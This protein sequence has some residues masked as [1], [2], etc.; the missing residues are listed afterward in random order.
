LK[1]ERKTETQ[2]NTI[3]DRKK[4]RLTRLA[5]HSPTCAGEHLCIRLKEEGRQR[6]KKFVA[7]KEITDST[8]E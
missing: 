4:N 8:K 6:K 7:R 1:T 2:Q 3:D 5:M